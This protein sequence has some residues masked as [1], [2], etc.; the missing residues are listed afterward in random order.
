MPILP[1]AVL[2]DVTTINYTLK[3]P[4]LENPSNTTFAGSKQIDICRCGSKTTDLGHIYTRYRCQPPQIRFATP[5]E[6]LWV[7]QAPLGQ[8]NLLRPANDEE[9]RHRKDIHEPT[10]LTVF[11]GTNL[12][13]PSGPCPR[14]RYQALATMRFLKSLSPSARSHISSISLLI[15]PYEEDCAHDQGAR[16]YVDLAHYIVEALPNFTTLCLN[17]WG[18][19]TKPVAKELALVLWKEGVGIRLS[20]DWWTEETEEFSEVE[21]FW[22]GLD[23][24]VVG[25]RAVW[26]GI[27]GAYQQ[28]GGDDDDDDGGG[29][30]NNE[31]EAPGKRSIAKELLVRMGRQRDVVGWEEEIPSLPDDEV[32]GDGEDTTHGQEGPSHDQGPHDF[33][34]AQQQTSQ[35]TTPTNN[36]TSSEDEDWSDALMTPHSPATGEHDSWQML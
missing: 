32:G 27:E 16:S 1:L 35:A 33:E 19:E 14:G 5:E 29:W 24:G 11:A 18:E 31:V 15:Q 10:D 9:L 21:A 6:E 12:L 34:D 7:L 26:Q 8:V 25:K 2:K 28:R 30:C 36:H 4:H 13:F 3:W 20:W 22:K 17:I 23:E